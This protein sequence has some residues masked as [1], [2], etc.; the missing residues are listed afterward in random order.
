M[1][2][3]FR[4]DSN[5]KIISDLN[6]LVFWHAFD[7]SG[8][9]SSQVGHGQV[10]LLSFFHNTI[11]IYVKIVIF[12]LYK[13]IIFENKLTLTYILGKVGCVFPMIVASILPHVEFGP[14]G[15]LPLGRRAHFIN[16]AEFRGIT[17]FSF[18]SLNFHY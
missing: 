8:P 4:R 13:R 2:Y 11:S 3:Y 17:K 1:F 10:N 12:C 16:Q 9:R 18:L 14:N 15:N 6:M 5:P 7:D